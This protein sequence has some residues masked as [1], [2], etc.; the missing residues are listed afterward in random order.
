M[1]LHDIILPTGG[2][3]SR[4]CNITLHYTTH[5]S[6]WHCMIIH[7]R[8]AE[9]RRAVVVLAARHLSMGRVACGAGALTTAASLPTFVGGLAARHLRVV[10]V[11]QRGDAAARRVPET[12]RHGM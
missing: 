1:A 11:A 6:A 7:Y 3:P 4:R 8:Q 2:A 9:P 10:D 5:A 12:Q